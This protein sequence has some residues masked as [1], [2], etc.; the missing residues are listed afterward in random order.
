M[1]IAIIGAKGLLGEACMRIL[2]LRESVE[3][4]GISREQVDLMVLTDVKEYM[5]A[6]DYDVCIYAAAISG[7]E[8][9][10]ANPIDAVRVNAV[11]PDIIAQISVQKGAKMVYISTDY[12]FDGEHESRPDEFT[13]PNPVNVY[14]NSKL[15]GERSIIARSPDFLVC[16]VSWLFGRGRS[17]F[18]DQVI[19]TLL[20]DKEESYIGDKFSVPNFCD[21]LAQ[22]MA[23]LL[24]REDGVSPSGVLHLV[25]DSE[26]ESWYSYAK[27]I[28]SSANHLGLTKSYS[29]SISNTDLADA[30]FFNEARPKHTA[31]ISKRLKAEYG[32]EVRNWKGGLEEYLQLKLEHYLTNG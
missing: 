25:S 22:A 31:M 6:L 19:N 18:V 23:D 15:E 30:H 21:D 26:P 7:L 28:L 29:Q 24:I 4:M 10:L 12:V 2:A 5:Q 8:D 16:R 14:G 3:T 20:E 27:E 32:V 1:K 17:T 9:C 11:V 13:S